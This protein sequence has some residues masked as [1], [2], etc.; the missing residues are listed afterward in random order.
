[1][2]KRK[3]WLLFIPLLLSAGMSLRAESISLRFTYNY[4]N[5]NG[6]DINTWINS[7]NTIW[8]DWQAL[9]GGTL[10]GEF[11]PLPSFTSYEGEIRFHIFSGLSLNLAASQFSYRKE[12]TVNYVNEADNQDETHFIKNNLKVIPIK[13]GF[14]FSYPV[15]PKLYV[16]IN[17][18]R[19]IVFVTYKSREEYSAIFNPSGK[20]FVYWY[21]YDFD[22][23][24]QGLGYYAA[25]GLE[26][27]V[28][29]FVSLTAEAEN[30]WSK[31]DGFKGDYTK[32]FYDS[33]LDEEG[34]ASLY[35]YESTEWGTGNSYSVLTGHK[36]RPENPDITNIRRGEIDLS[37]LSLKFGLRFKF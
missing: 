28:L 20:E 30:I 11:S 24:S 5:I 36:E 8:T 23:R 9:N 31:T 17:A 16:Y 1:M 12:G 26:F 19:H 6:S 32:E 14:S 25:L 4:G 15:L 27:D 29:K 10:E 22:F 37:G 21:T 35:F 34:K 2:R 13:I 18:G 3:Y 7:Y 33:T